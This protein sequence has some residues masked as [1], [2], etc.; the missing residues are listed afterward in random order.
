MAIGVSVMLLSSTAPAGGQGQQT[1]GQQGDT[2]IIDHAMD[3]SDEQILRAELAKMTPEE[4][5]NFIMIIDGNRLVSNKLSTIAQWE[6]QNLGTDGVWRNILG[7]P[8][9]PI[10]RPGPRPIDYWVPPSA[11]TGGDGGS[12]GGFSNTGGTTSG[13]SIGGSSATS[14]GSTSSA[15]GTADST[16]GTIL[17]GTGT[18]TGSTSGT[19]SG[20]GSN[21]STS[22]NDCCTQGEIAND[23]YTTSGL[24]TP[25]NAVSGPF[26]RLIAF[27]TI[28]GVKA[29]KGQVILP[30]DNQVHGL[31]SAGDSS[32]TNTPYIYLG[33]W[34][35]DTFSPDPPALDA[36]LQFSCLRR[37]WNA[38]VNPDYQ[39]S[40]AT[41]KGW[42]NRYFDFNP[43]A[44]TR[45]H[46]V[47][48]NFK[49]E[50]TNYG[51]YDFKIE[52]LD[53]N[54]VTST[55]TVSVVWKGQVGLNWFPTSG[56]GLQLKRTTTI[57]L[58]NSGNSGKYL[59]G[60][61]NPSK[62]CGV[63]WRDWMVLWKQPP[64]LPV[65]QEHWTTWD[66]PAT[67]G[68][69][70][71]GLPTSYLTKVKSTKLFGPYTSEIVGIE[72]NKITGAGE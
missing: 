18:G 37:K 67:L 41:G 40:G 48:T 50:G 13:A 30:A 31:N 62:L 46:Q 17:P 3:P 6:E 55:V 33:G 2:I 38:F 32:T 22:S 43:G 64:V 66:A 49:A 25:I 26:R 23:D 59:W 34:G 7:E 68:Q 65:L 16:G 53:N 15:S 54:A 1:S 45:W 21:G 24:T 19:S 20:V 27:A 36:G 44:T 70:G 52:L 57:A 35:S 61:P 51:G 72:I 69:V 56:T 11:D 47:V 10:P 4:R 9:P 60:G 28:G 29:I 63:E 71:N 42:V 8:R 12:A 5:E 14:T 58:L 39:V